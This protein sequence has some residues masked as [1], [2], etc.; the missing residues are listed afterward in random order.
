[1]NYRN[2]VQILRGIAVLV[3]VLFHLEIPSFGSGFLGVDVFFVIS[4]F[5]MAILFDP[6]APGTFYLRRAR[7]LLPAYF[8]TVIATLVAVTLTLTPNEIQQLFSQVA[9]ALGFTSNMGFW[10]KD[11]Y[12]DKNEFKPLLHLWSL[13]VEIQFY[14]LVPVVALVVRRYRLAGLATLT[15]LSALLCFALLAEHPKSAFFL[16][17]ARMWEF[18]LGYGVGALLGA[19]SIGT[20]HAHRFGLLG[21]VAILLIPAVPITGTGNGFLDGHPG[22]AAL[23]ITLATAVVI[24]TGL[25]TRLVTSAP[26]RALERLGDWSYSIY[27]AHFPVIVILLSPPFGGTVTRAPTPG[28][29]VEVIAAV[30]IA[31]FA[32]YQFIEKPFRRALPRWGTLAGAMVTT[33]GLLLAAPLLQLENMSRQERQIF[34]SQTDRDTYRCGL[35]WQLRHPTASICPLNDPPVVNGTIFLVG[36]SYADSLKQTLTGIADRHGLKVNLTVENLPLM[37]SGRMGVAEII[38]EARK[39]DASAIVLHY[40]P[41]AVDGQT[42]EDLAWTAHE[43][44]IVTRVI[45]P[46][47]RQPKNVPSAQLR[48]LQTGEP[49]PRLTLDDYRR[50]HAQ[51][52]AR[53]QM[54][55]VPGFVIYQ[56][57]QDLCTPEC[58]V[59][60]ASGKLLYWDEHH[61]TL[62]GSRRLAPTLERLVSAVAREAITAR[63]PHQ[64]M[65][66]FSRSDSI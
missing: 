6:K 43:L 33:V 39:M 55:T 29:L 2:D 58:Q 45:M 46:V 15:I 54:I 57:A 11:S 13:A 21:L 19:R 36:N 56:I 37:S 5:L 59:K 20:R 51:R 62:T 30:A 27:L 50:F 65:M 24:A 47:P 31:S 38:A 14:A 17:P 9:N 32:L 41:D 26:G 64:P 12:F 63:A 3:V 49:P 16:L 66:P 25:P 7:R 53:L 44:G 28:R 61:L 10:A 22:L 23:A 35:A 8:A 52:L 60:D 4:G 18:L 34:A 1:M 48:A 40:S 42:I